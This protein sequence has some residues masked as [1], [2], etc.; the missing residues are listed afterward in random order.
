MYLLFAVY[1]FNS[2]AIDVTNN[3]EHAVVCINFRNKT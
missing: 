3:R 1:N 2:A